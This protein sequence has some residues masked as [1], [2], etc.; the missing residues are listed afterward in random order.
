[1]E[2]DADWDRRGPLGLPVWLTHSP[3]G[4][5]ICPSRLP[6]IL[7]HFPWAR[8]CAG[9]REQRGNSLAPAHKASQ[10]RNVQEGSAIIIVPTLQKAGLSL[11]ACD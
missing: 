1:M 4:P 11:R 8:L 10:G 6:F 2:G 9:L 7:Q 5:L 3:M